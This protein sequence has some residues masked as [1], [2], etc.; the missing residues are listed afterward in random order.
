ME[1]PRSPMT[2]QLIID[3]VAGRV[4]NEVA[5]HIRTQVSDAL[6]GYVMG[7]LPRDVMCSI[8][9]AERD[10]DEVAAGISVMRHALGVSCDAGSS[11]SALAD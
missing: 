9:E 4:S 3:F 6:R 5:A 2:A 10:D 8:A 11:R 7:T 1:F